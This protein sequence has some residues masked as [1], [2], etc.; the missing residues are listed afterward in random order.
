MGTGRSK[1]SAV[2]AIDL[3]TCHSGYA[4]AFRGDSE[5]IINENWGQ[6]AGK[7]FYKTTTAVLYNEKGEFDSFGLTAEQKY[8]HPTDDLQRENL[9][10]FKNFKMQLY[11][12]PANVC[13]FITLTFETH[14]VS[15]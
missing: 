6:E 7:S 10:F 9:Q 4:V 8:L 3:G 11:D 1:Y 2:V 12:K 15:L 14:T 13:T 5:V